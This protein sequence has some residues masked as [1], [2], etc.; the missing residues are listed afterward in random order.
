[1]SGAARA[2]VPVPGGR[3]QRLAAMGAIVSGVAGGMVAEGVRR[4]ARGERPQLGDLLLTPANARRVTDQLSRLRGAAMKVG[5]LLSMD[6]GDLLPAELTTVL[7]A[8]RA[9]A[10]AMPMSQVV[11]ALEAGLGKGWEDAFERFSF[12][13]MAAASI[14]QVHRARLRDGREVAVKIQY[15]GVRRSIDSDVANVAS[16]LRLSGLLPRGIDLEPLLAEAC[17]QLHAE[18]DYRQEAEHLSGFASLLAGSPGFAVPGV[19][20]ELSGETVLCMTYVAGE[21]IESL[22]AHPAGER[23]RVA[24][25]IFS[26]LFRELFEFRL[27]QTDPNFA[28]Y[29]YD[30]ASGRVGLLDFGATRACPAEMVLG[31]RDL[32][33]AGATGERTAIEAAARRI[34]YFAAGMPSARLAAVVELFRM[35]SEPLRHDG[36]YD[37]GQSDLSA[38]ISRAGMAL[39]RQRDFWHTPPA[40]AL[41]LHRKM[42]GLYLLAARLGARVDAAAL[43]HEAR[44]RM[45]AG[46]A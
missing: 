7:A 41:F 20:D 5:Q 15:P 19:I 40:D 4:L 14:G 13:P 32:L 43:W 34:G 10:R 26:L 11:A 2:P 17:R 8:L 30:A 45:D 33:D 3:V 25:A 18:A 9:D 23:D 37:F 36:P 21:P 12:S 44:R 46:A 1:M 22:A 35:A 29:R 38:R 28:N 42:G 27:L 31:Y 39:G 16:L 6:A 24:T